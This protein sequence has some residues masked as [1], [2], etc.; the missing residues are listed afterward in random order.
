MSRMRAL[1]LLSAVT[2][3][4]SACGGGRSHKEVLGVTL[5]EYQELT[6]FLKLI[7]SED[8]AKR[9][10]PHIRPAVNRIV[11]LTEELESLGA[12]PAENKAEVAEL[13]RQ[14]EGAIKACQNQVRRASRIN[15]VSEALACLE[16]LPQSTE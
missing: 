8:D 14:L 9:L 6:E 16:R 15:G 10:R 2:V 3:L 7:E 12:V 13:Q 1:V 4:L 11:D 5:R